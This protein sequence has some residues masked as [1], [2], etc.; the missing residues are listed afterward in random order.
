MSIIPELVLQQMLVQGIRAFREDERLLR[1]LFRNFTLEEVEGIQKFF[2]DDSIDIS[3]NYPDADLKLP[4][5]VIL[6]KN[7]SESQAFLRDYQ[8]STSDWM[9]GSLP[10]PKAELLGDQT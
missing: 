5:I 7:E 4:A 9:E 8:Q 10:L 2:R 3:L 6:M 1:M